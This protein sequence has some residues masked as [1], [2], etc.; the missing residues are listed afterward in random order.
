MTLSK[1]LQVFLL[2]A[3]ADTDVVRRL[4]RRLTRDGANVWRDREKLLPGQDWVYEI[5]RAIHNSDVVVVCLSRRF[6]KQGG[7]RHEELHMAVE[8]ANSLSADETYLIPARLER[9]DLPEPLGR[10]ERVD[11][12]ETDGYG[13]LLEALRQQTT[14]ANR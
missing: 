13:K 4:H 6:N 7:Y 9:C 3:R 5:H 14:A 1:T 11:L 10:W 12:F 8:K 2:Y